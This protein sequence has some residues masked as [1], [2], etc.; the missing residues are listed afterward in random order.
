WD[1]PLS[2]F[3]IVG[4]LGMTGIIINDS[5]VLVP[6]ID[7]YA[8]DRGLIPS[9]IDG[10]ANR[11]RPVMLT[12]LTTVLG[13]A[14]LLFERSSQA[15]FLKPTVITLVYGLGFGMIIVLLVVPSLI[16]MQSDVRRRVDAFKRGLG[17]RAKGPRAMLNALAVLSAVWLA[18]TMG[19][20][21]VTGALVAPLGGLV[22]ALDAMPAMFG[23]FVIFALGMVA[24]IVL[25]YAASLAALVISRRRA[26]QRV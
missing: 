6:T 1:V 16:A 26:E 25:V 5:I 12:T 4:L 3:T 10:A 17:F 15:Q 19:Y 21:A 8:E 24:M 11:L 14:P 18:A 23:A 22:P 9:I 7:E 2:M 20:A 13:L